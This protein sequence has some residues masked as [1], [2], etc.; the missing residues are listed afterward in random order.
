MARWGPWKALVLLVALMGGGFAVPLYDAVAFHS[1]PGPTRIETDVV[2]APGADTGHAPACAISH[3]RATARF[4][5][6][7]P[8]S[9][10]DPF[11]ATIR[12]RVRFTPL[13]LQRLT[14]YEQLSR[15]PPSIA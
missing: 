5:P 12:A 4:S 1:R 13:L 15:A 14:L 3:A 9:L 6:G 7:V 11:S 10:A 2:A 8:A